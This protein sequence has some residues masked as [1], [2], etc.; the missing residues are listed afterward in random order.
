MPQFHKE[1]YAGKERLEFWFTKIVECF[2]IKYFITV[3][4][5]SQK[6]FCFHMKKNE[7]DEWQI[8]EAEKLPSWIRALEKELSIAIR[9][10]K[11]DRL[12]VSVR[13]YKKEI[14]MTW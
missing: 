13:R 2:H 10:R 1:I 14:Q 9:E 4:D 8:L 7:N 6:L 5:Q 11:P 12:K 3:M